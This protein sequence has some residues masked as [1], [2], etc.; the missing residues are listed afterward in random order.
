[1][2]TMQRLAAVKQSGMQAISSMDIFVLPEPLFHR[3]HNQMADPSDPRRIGLN[4]FTLSLI[5]GLMVEIFQMFTDLDGIMVRV[6]ENYGGPKVP[7]MTWVANGAVKFS[8]PFVNQQQDYIRFITQLR[9]SVCAKHNKQVIFRTWD[10]SGFSP[11]KPARYIWV[12]HKE[13]FHYSLSACFY[14]S[15]DSM[16]DYLWEKI[17]M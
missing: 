4:N 11:N 3:F 9:E 15:G 1:M 14:F 17:W 13:P 5:D 10:T 2:E 7:N 6:G 12:W 16:W 8:D